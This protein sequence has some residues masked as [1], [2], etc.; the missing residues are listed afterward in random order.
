MSFPFS[1]SGTAVLDRKRAAPVAAS[2]SSSSLP[3][4]LPGGLKAVCEDVPAKK[5][6]GVAARA[7]PPL[8]VRRNPPLTR[9]EWLRQLEVTEEQAAVIVN[10]EQ[11]TPEWLASR[12]GRITSSNFG[13]AIGDNKYTSP[14]ALL[15]QM[16]WGEF[17]G[18]AA[19]RWGSEH[20]DV[21]RDEYIAI[22]R[23][24]IAAAQQEDDV[25]VDIDVKECG[26]VINPSRA[27]MGNSPDGLIT[28]TYASGR[29]ERGLLEIKC[30]FRQEFYAPDPVPLY[31]Y[32]QVQGT[33]GNMG[34]PWCDF[35]VWTPTG[36]QVTR[37]PFN[38][39]Y[40]DTRL[41]PGVTSFYFD[42]YLPLAL[43]KENGELVPNTL[44]RP[45]IILS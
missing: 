44:D 33:M 11:G 27:W 37:V 9:E 31:Y 6:G 8:L 14:R 18:N 35:V 12:V 13:A 32:A 4:A 15:K 29:T 5:R 41:L 30:P 1:I 43:A 7:P 21:A 19:T 22:V 24:Q 20:E 36:V 3:F 17:K 45:P 26:L 10:Y 34:L 38:Q 40:W 2:S 16:L 42:Q 23:A 28:L 25:L 39:E